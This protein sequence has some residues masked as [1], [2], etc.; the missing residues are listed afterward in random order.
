[1]RF[2]L[3]AA[4]ALVAVVCV[5]AQQK[6]TLQAEVHPPLVRPGWGGVVFVWVGVQLGVPL[7]ELSAACLLL[8]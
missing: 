4:T 3:A 6:G 7:C 1:M 2:G 5:K 8:W